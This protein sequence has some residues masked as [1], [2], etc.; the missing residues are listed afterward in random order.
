MV[1]QAMCVRTWVVVWVQLRLSVVLSEAPVESQ[2]ARPS[3]GVAQAWQ[4]AQSERTRH[5]STQRF[6]L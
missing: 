6:G 2:G 1:R 5:V 4:K 3:V